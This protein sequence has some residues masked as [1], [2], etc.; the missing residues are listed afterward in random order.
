MRLP[1]TRKRGTE[2]VKTKQKERKETKTKIKS[3]KCGHETI[4]YVK[5][6]GKLECKW[7]LL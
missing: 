7:F 1:S 4:S 2:N 5:W 3:I 6:Y